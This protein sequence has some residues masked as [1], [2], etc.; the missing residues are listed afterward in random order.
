MNNTLTIKHITFNRAPLLTITVSIG[1]TSKGERMLP[2]PY[3][4]VSSAVLAFPTLILEL[5]R[6][7]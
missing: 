5:P 1:T 3:G 6:R 4:V 2:A 7:D